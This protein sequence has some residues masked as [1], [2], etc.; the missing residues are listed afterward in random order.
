[1]SVVTSVNNSSISPT[2]VFYE[3]V[4]LKRLIAKTVY[5]NLSWKKSLEKDMG[6]TYSWTV[7]GVQAADTTSLVEGV[8]VVPTSVT[9]STITAQVKEYGNAVALASLAGNTNVVDGEKFLLDQIEQKGAYTVDQLIR[10]EVFGSCTTFGS[11]LFAANKKASIAAITASDVLTLADVMR[12]KAILEGNNVPSFKDGHMAMVI[13]VGQKYD[14]TS[15]STTGGF[16]DLAKQNPA[17]IE[18]IKK[19]FR[20]AEDGDMRPVGEYAGMTLFATSLNPVVSN[21][22]TNVHYA[23]AWGDQSLGAVEL[24][25]EKFKI[26]RKDADKGTYD[27]LEMIKLAMGYKVAFAAK[28]LSESTAQARVLAIGSAVTAF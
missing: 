11:N 23:A 21:G 20:I 10:D 2:N 8:P 4:P 27:I 16:L 5:Y 13:S 25:S 18:D 17:G 24:D 3:R 12:A 28:N 15:N 19:T 22:T 6:R 9:S 7:G 26:F 1:M 14:L